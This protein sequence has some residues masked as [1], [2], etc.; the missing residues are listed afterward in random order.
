MRNNRLLG[1]RSCPC[2]RRPVPCCGR[3]SPG[4]TL[5]RLLVPSCNSNA[6]L[7][8]RRDKTVPFAFFKVDANTGQGLC[9]AVFELR[10]CD[11]GR[12]VQTRTSDALGAVRFSAVPPGRYMLV[13][14]CPP[15][16]YAAEEKIFPVVVD[17]FDNVY[18]NGAPASEFRAFNVPLLVQNASEALST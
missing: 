15:S 10:C 5:A 13:E 1:D 18:I 9:G 3:N 7:C 11:K 6:P 2:L 12:A 8:C 14:V 4:R 17:C 16:G